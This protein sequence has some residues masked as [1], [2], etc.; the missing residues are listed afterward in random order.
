M[1]VDN[2]GKRLKITKEI[3]KDP[4]HFLISKFYGL[5]VP[6]GFRVDLFAAK[7]FKLIC[8]NLKPLSLTYLKTKNYRFGSEK[9]T[10]TTSVK[11]LREVISSSPL[12]RHP[13]KVFCPY[14]EKLVIP[15][16]LH[17]LDVG[18]FVLFL[19]TAGFWAILLFAMFLFVRRCPACN[20]NLRG[21]K[22]LSKEDR[23]ADN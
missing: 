17:K 9:M 15:R 12:A 19:F 22:P 23:T 14:C 8:G 6:K 2:I 3:I 5:E 11:K 4:E 1:F 10:Y 16:R 20:Y 13:R 7:K 21:F 18:D